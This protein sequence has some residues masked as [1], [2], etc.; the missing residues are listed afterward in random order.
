M[1][2]SK[3]PAALIDRV[4]ESLLKYV[5]DSGIKGVL[6]SDMQKF[7][8]ENIGKEQYDKNTQDVWIRNVLTPYI[9]RLNKRL[10]YKRSDG[11][12]AYQLA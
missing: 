7:L 2:H 6:Y 12:Y 9:T 5:K 1:S 4:F 8:V 10:V 11:T 3:R